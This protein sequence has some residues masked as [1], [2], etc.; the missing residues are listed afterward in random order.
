M[1]T[2]TPMAMVLAG[3]TVDELSVLTQ[4]RPKS[5]V[6]FGGMYRVIDFALTN[7]VRSGIGEVFILSQYRPYALM[8]HVMAGEPW[9]LYGHG[10]AM[11]FLPPYQAAGVQDW[12]RGTAD[13]LYQNLDVIEQAESD[14]V[15]VLSGDHIYSMDYRPLIAAHRAKN[16]DLTAVFKR[17][18]QPAHKRSPFGLADVAPDGRVLGYAEKPEDPHSDLASLTI[19]LFKRE[20]LVRQLRANALTGHTFQLYDEV[21]PAMVAEGRVY[22]HVLDGYWGYARTLDSYYQATLDVA[23]PGG[24]VDLAAWRVMTNEES[25]GLG[26]APGA[27][28]GPEAEIVDATLAPGARVDGIVIRSVVGPGVTVERGAVVRSSVLFRNVH[29]AS[30]AV[31]E[32][33]LAD[34][35]SSFAAGC[36]VGRAYEP[37]NP[38]PPNGRWPK[39]L[40]CGLTVVGLDAQVGAGVVVGRNAVVAPQVAVPPGTEIADGATFAPGG[41]A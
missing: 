5:A 21:L 13:A 28:I 18:P 15:L 30:G 17:M 6:P 16:A 8:E 14:D 10:R 39:S 36:R 33:V 29:V 11:R 7:L 40:S 38:P 31:L 24:P 32:R 9:G 41:E 34:R 37:D 2:K 1:T 20:A 12:Y 3:G 26:T 27:L 25:Q 19:Y 35:A 4:F 23:L 22:A